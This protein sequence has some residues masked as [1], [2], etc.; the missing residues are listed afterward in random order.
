MLHEIARRNDL[1]LA[2]EHIGLV[3]YPTNASPVIAMVVGVN[4]GHNG[5]FLDMLVEEILACPR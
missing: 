2:R 5:Q 3:D 1:N 4:D